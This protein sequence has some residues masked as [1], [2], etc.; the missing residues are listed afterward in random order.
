MMDQTWDQGKRWKKPF[1][2]E[3]PNYKIKNN[4]TQQ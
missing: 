2:E 4:Q 3:L 1:F